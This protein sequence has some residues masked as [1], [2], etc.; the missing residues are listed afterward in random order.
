MSLINKMLQD[1]D[2]RGGDGTRADASSLVRPVSYGSRRGLSPAAIG[3]GVVA[4]AALGAGGFYAWK[5]VRGGQQAGPA[6]A[7]S[8]AARGTPATKEGLQGEPLGAAGA[9]LHAAPAAGAANAVHAGA[10]DSAA[11]GAAT[12]ASAVVQDPAARLATNG[13][14]AI[15]QNGS[16]SRAEAPPRDAAARGSPAHRTAARLPDVAAQGA[17]GHADA[18]RSAGGGVEATAGKDA[19]TARQAAAPTPG[20]PKAL[21]VT[22]R[23][24]EMRRVM[25]EAKP[26]GTHR[27]ASQSRAAPTGAMARPGADT[28]KVDT[29][30]AG[31]NSQQKAENEYRR[32]LAK[33]QDA[34]VSEAIAGLEQAVFLYPRHDAARQT[35]VSLLIEGGR[36]SDA[37][38]H[39]IFAT[40]LDPRQ[41]NMAM[42]LARLQLEHGGNALETLQR[43]LPYA[44]S[45]ADFRALMAG[46]L[47]RANRHQEAAEHYQAALRLQPANGVWWMGMGISLQADKRNAEAKAAFQRARDSGNLSAE[48]QGFVERR[49]QQL[50]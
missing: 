46:V 8:Q 36:T 23:P 2:A 6:P 1:L 30:E 48:L 22:A 18:A 21:P 45:N 5:L 33:L 28:A 3:A 34:R 12:A 11:R 38:R 4:L 26:G 27:G 10:G 17:P 49:L 15:A 20:R 35:L 25:G 47:Q 40:S 14:S 32:A 16:A 24:E 31:L 29:A 43:S 39:L 41:A 19:G 42:L 37:M 9:A 7:A 13:A 44:E 50:D